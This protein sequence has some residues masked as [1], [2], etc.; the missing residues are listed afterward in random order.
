MGKSSIESK[1]VYRF[2]KKNHFILKE[3]NHQKFYFKNDV[4]IGSEYKFKT[5][6][7][8]LGLNHKDAKYGVIKDIRDSL[9]GILENEKIDSKTV[10]KW[11]NSNEKIIIIKS[12]IGE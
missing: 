8:N 2:L 1:K 12:G 5:S 6:R 7:L 9:I 10:E 11:I 3:S 4:K